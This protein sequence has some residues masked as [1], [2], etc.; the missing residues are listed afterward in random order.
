LL[1]GNMTVIDCAPGS[2]LLDTLNYLNVH[3]IM[4]LFLSHAD[5][6][7]IGGLMSLL[8]EPRIKIHNIYLNPDAFKRNSVWVGFRIALK[9]ARLRFNTKIHTELTTTLSKNIK[10]NKMTIEILSPVPEIAASGAG[11]VDL[12]GRRLYA[13][14][15]SAV[16]GLTYHSRR[17]AL[18]TGDIDGTG[19]QNL[20]E[21]EPNVGSYLLVFPHHGG[22]VQNTDEV[23]FAAELCNAVKPSIVV[24]S[25]GRDKYENPQPEIIQG[26]RTAV[27]DCHIIC[28]QLSKNCSASISGID[29]THLTNL[30]AKGKSTSGCCGGSIEIDV[31]KEKIVCKPIITS[32]IDF[33]RSNVSKSLCFKTS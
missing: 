11:G 33:I 31:E 1:D 2:V 32:H 17:I 13:N 4:H 26:V 23:K 22:K 5:A 21:S 27:P 29:L 19:L 16:I 28:T 12:K 25:I 8:S 10:S 14:S 15:M 3:E 18:F 20:L 30:P 6:D 7:H 24:F 9:D